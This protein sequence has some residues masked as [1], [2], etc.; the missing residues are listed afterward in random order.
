MNERPVHIIGAGGIGIAVGYALV[1]AGRQ[2]TLIEKDPEKLAVGKK[3]G[4]QVEGHPPLRAIPFIDFNEWLAPKDTLLLLCTKTFDN[5]AVLEKIPDKTLLLPIQNGF[6]ELLDQQEHFGE[7]IASFVSECERHRPYTRIT[8]EG[9]LHIGRRRDTTAE[10]EAVLDELAATLNNNPL[11]A[12]VRVNNVLPYKATKLMYNAAISP[13]AASAGVDNSVLLSD[14]MAK[15]YFFKLILENYAILKNANKEMAKIGPFHPDVVSRIL[16]TP[17]LPEIMAQFF[18]PSL[19]GTYCSMAPDIGT[20]QTEI[21]AYNGYLVKLA[22]DFPCPYNKAAVKLVKTI[23]E[24][25]A[26][27]DYQHLFIM[28]EELAKQGIQL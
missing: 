25:R 21:D 17:G 26:A 11:F 15:K 1:N 9:E 20:P 23:T 2:V 14:K 24:K 3:E 28:Q 27:P 6:D 10:N 8:R 13:L 18:K 5:A 12:V 7:A 16:K 22:G 19:R 4:F